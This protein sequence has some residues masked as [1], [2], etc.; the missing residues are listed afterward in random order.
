MELS[1]AMVGLIKG[2]L[3]TVAGTPKITLTLAVRMTAN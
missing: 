3:V 1:A 2:R